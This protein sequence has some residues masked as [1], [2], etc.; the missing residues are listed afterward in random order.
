M[1]HERVPKEDQPRPVLIEH[2]DGS[3]ITVKQFMIAAHECLSQHKDKIINN[4]KFLLRVPLLPITVP[5]P[6]NRD[7]SFDPDKHDL[8]FKVAQGTSFPDGSMLV[9]VEVFLEGELGK[10][11][12][13][14][15]AAQREFAAGMASRRARSME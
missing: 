2:A 9:G 11:A 8:F 14:F 5:E 6:E 15:C 13:A 4:R 12:E 10:S 7:L 3:P 1:I